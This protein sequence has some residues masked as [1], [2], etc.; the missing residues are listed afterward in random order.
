MAAFIETRLRPCVY[1]SIYRQISE[2]QQLYRSPLPEED[3][4]CRIG[5]EGVVFSYSLVFVQRSQLDVDAK[6][7]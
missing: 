6:P 5:E 1:W 2:P 4:D 7:R 3:V